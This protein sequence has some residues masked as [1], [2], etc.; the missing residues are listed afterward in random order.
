MACSCR[1]VRTLLSGDVDL[2]RALAAQNAGE[3]QQL[4]DH[5]AP[6]STQVPVQRRRDAEALRHLFKINYYDASMDF[7]SEDLADLSKTTRV[8]TIMLAEDWRGG[9]LLAGFRGGFSKTTPKLLLLIWEHRKEKQPPYW[10][11]VGGSSDG[12][13]STTVPFSQR[14]QLHISIPVTSPFSSKPR[15]P[16]I[17]SNVWLAALGQPL[18]HQTTLRFRLPQPKPSRPR[19]WWDSDRRDPQG[20]SD[21]SEGSFAGHARI[22]AVVH[23]TEAR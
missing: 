6:S 21:I 11:S 5:R 9:L 1:F 20:T 18:W 16:S 23:V 3:H 2:R 8:L 10:F 15:V 19:S 7:G 22:G 13:F 4:T 17:V 14:Y 12:A